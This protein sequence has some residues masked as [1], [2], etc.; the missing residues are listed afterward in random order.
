MMLLLLLM[1]LICPSVFKLLEMSFSTHA[2][3]TRTFST[4]LKDLTPPPPVSLDQ[5][6]PPTPVTLDQTP[7]PTPVTLTLL[8][9]TAVSIHLRQSKGRGFT[10]AST[11]KVEIDPVGGV[12]ELFMSC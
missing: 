9:F 2:L 8:A 10:G 3:I 1:T 12:W 6:P 11:L 4:T 7:P 5:T